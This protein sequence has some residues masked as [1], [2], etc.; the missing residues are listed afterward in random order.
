MDREAWWATVHGVAN[1]SAL[2]GRRQKSNRVWDVDE[3][4]IITGCGHMFKG[5]PWDVLA[6]SLAL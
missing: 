6:A 5:W 3:A 2:R 4:L 1:E